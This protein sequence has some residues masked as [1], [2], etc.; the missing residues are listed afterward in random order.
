M[1]SDSFL[2]RVSTHN[3]GAVSF[4]PY[5]GHHFHDP[6]RGSKTDNAGPIRRVPHCIRRYWKAYGEHP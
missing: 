4:L 5:H 3:H 1:H 2:Y 6:S